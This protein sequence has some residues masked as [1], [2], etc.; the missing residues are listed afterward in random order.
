MHILISFSP[1]CSLCPFLF[2]LIFTH[3]G[4]SQYFLHECR[5][6]WQ[7]DNPALKFWVLKMLCP[8]SLW[9]CLP[10]FKIFKNW[11]NSFCRCSIFV[12][13]LSFCHDCGFRWSLA[14]GLCSDTACLARGERRDS[15]W[16]F[17]DLPLAHLPTWDWCGLNPSTTVVCCVDQIFLG[18][19]S[20]VMHKVMDSC[21][22][23]V[24]PSSRVPRCPSFASTRGVTAVICKSCH[25]YP[26]LSSFHTDCCSRSA[27]KL[28]PWAYPW[29]RS[30]PFALQNQ[31]WFCSE[32][33]LS[34]GLVWHHQNLLFANYSPAQLVF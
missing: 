6:L 29:P 12:C 33:A 14:Q 8:W 1:S 4:F 21:L 30:V 19:T 15:E 28:H 22:I 2:L 13:S 18:D 9:S 5:E 7:V 11:K 26:R 34:S 32:A 17:S 20:S 31:H 16:C 27:R 10:C 23:L 25:N 24:A 3:N